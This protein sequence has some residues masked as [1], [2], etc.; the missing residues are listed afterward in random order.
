MNLFL[1]RKWLDAAATMGELYI[2]DVFEDFVLE[3]PVKDGKPGSCILPGTYNIVLAPSPH[4]MANPDPYYRKY[5]HAM[6]LLVDVPYR[7]GIEIHP[8][9]SPAQTLGCLLLG[10]VHDPDRLEQSRAAFDLFYPKIHDAAARCDLKI[11]ITGGS[12]Q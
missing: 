9:V 10:R 11:T 3:L 8:G 5:D 2:E 4:F 7:D 6:P 12:P 1:N